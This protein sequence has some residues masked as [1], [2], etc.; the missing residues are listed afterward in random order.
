MLGIEIAVGNLMEQIVCGLCRALREDEDGALADLIRPV[1]LEN[2]LN[3]RQGAG[4]VLMHERVEREKLEV[5][6]LDGRG[7]NRLAG[8]GADL[9]FECA[10][11]FEPGA[12]GKTGAEF[13]AAGESAI[14]VAL[15]VFRISLPVEGAIRVGLVLDSNTREDADGIGPA[16]FIDGAC[17]VGVKGRIRGIVGG[18]AGGGGGSEKRLG[19]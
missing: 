4:L 2:L 7:L 12:G 8:V 15:L 9:D 16:A 1:A 10:A 14:G 18:P 19:G 11:I 5:F 6:V 13:G 17:S 3:L